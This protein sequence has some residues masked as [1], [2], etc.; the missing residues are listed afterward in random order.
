MSDVLHSIQATV[1][2]AMLETQQV[3]TPID[4]SLAKAASARGLNAEMIKRAC[5]GANVLRFLKLPDR[6]ED[7]PLADSKEVI[8][9]V[10]GLE[11]TSMALLQGGLFSEYEGDELNFVE[12]LGLWREKEASL[13]VI[14]IEEARPTYQQDVTLVARQAM[15]LPENL[16]KSADAANQIAAREHREVTG[17]I[18]KLAHAFSVRPTPSF[19]RFEHDVIVKYGEELARPL[20]NLIAKMATLIDARAG[21]VD[22]KV[23]VSNTPEVEAFA[24]VVG[25]SEKFA[26]ASALGVALEKEAVDKEGQLLSRFRGP[27]PVAPPYLP[28]G[29]LLEKAA[30]TLDVGGSPYTVSGPSDVKDLSSLQ[31]LLGAQERA[32]RE[33]ERHTAEMGRLTSPPS[34]EDVLKGKKSRVDYE[35]AVRERQRSGLSSIGQALSGQSILEALPGQD[36]ARDFQSKALGAV[37]DKARTKAEEPPKLDKRFNDAV[38]NLRRQAIIQ[39]LVKNDEVL[40]HQP[41][42]SVVGMYNTLVRL[43]PNLSQEPE[44]VRAFL[45]SSIDEMAVD[46]F[47]VEQIL[48]AERRIAEAKGQMPRRP[49]LD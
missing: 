16:R 44:V 49:M 32:Q 29:D 22:P 12:H 48:K 17:T 19:E 34:E 30:L 8:K 37:L 21:R 47:T 1:R 4:Q 43:A 9:L 28:W 40:Q 35:D 33:S 11:K 38:D 23:L 46:P 41:E 42:E 6:R 20:T 31:S 10:Q 15:H 7:Y 27:E 2:D 5:E 3:G 25:A 13:N 36:L 45:R 26:K 24:G 14:D 39:S 18:Q